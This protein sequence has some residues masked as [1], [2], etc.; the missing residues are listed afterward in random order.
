MA[1]MRS[2]FGGSDMTNVVATVRLRERSGAAIGVC[3]FPPVLELGTSAAEVLTRIKA[4][5]QTIILPT[6][7]YQFVK[8]IRDDIGSEEEAP[9]R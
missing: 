7:E 5:L 3:E 2:A 6:N 8:I 1:P 4:R 9:L